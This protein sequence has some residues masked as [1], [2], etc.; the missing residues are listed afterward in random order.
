[1]KQNKLTPERG[2]VVNEAAGA[3]WHP[4]LGGAPAPAPTTSPARWRRG[5]IATGA[6]VLSIGLSTMTF[7]LVDDG[8]PAV[9]APDDRGPK[10]GSPATPDYK[11]QMTRYLV[12]RGLIPPQSIGD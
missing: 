1:M 8:P 10:Q 7:Y 11:E 3:S 12:E 6:I 5:W 2:S 9:T 4:S